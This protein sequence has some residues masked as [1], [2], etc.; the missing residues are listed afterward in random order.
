MDAGRQAVSHVGRRCRQPIGGHQIWPGSRAARLLRAWP[1]AVISLPAFCWLERSCRLPPSF[2][3]QTSRGENEGDTLY[4][5]TTSRA[6]PSLDKVL[7]DASSSAFPVR[8]QRQPLQQ[9]TKYRNGN[10]SPLTLDS[11]GDSEQRQGSYRAGR[12]ILSWRVSWTGVFQPPKVQTRNEGNATSLHPG[13]K[14]QASCRPKCPHLVM[15]LMHQHNDQY[16]ISV[17]LPFVIESFQKMRA[18]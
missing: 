15:V 6:T 2:S 11:R 8:L 7:A 14:T 4:G 12:H 17:V 10:V 9:Q 5:D 13:S 1:A 3:R 16:L 18:L